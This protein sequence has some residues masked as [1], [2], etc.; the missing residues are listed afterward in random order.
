MSF[1]I[2]LQCLLVAC[3][4]FST[5]SALRFLGVQQHISQ[6]G[7]SKTFLSAGFGK[8][9]Q[10]APAVVSQSA[11]GKCMCG[12]LET[13]VSCCKSLHEG[14]VS[15]P[16]S[17]IRSRYSA[18]ASSNIDYIISTTS[19]TSS[20]YKAFIDTPIAPTNGIKRWTKSIKSNMIEQYQYVRMEIDSVNVN[21]NGLEATVSWRHLAIRIA[22]N[23]MYP[24]EEI[25]ALANLDGTWSYVKGDVKRPT[26]E[27]SQTM[28]NDWPPLMGLE[29]KIED[30]KEDTGVAARA[31]GSSK[32][33]MMD[34]EGSKKFKPKMNQITASK[35]KNSE[36]SGSP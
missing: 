11:E 27:Q 21:E 18:Y 28:M 24:I 32:R 29:L 16:A 36:R 9:P 17:L 34:F 6:K 7:V 8:A 15:D 14:A 2:L 5:S 22:D 25:S 19:K 12:S 1:V 20:D 31:S 13:Y 33:S 30:P 10:A 26:P 23:V 4:H 3:F 35:T